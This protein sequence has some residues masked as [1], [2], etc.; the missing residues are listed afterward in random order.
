MT[1][2]MI[3]P[4]AFV[5]RP[6]AVLFDLD[7]TLYDFATAQPKAMEAARAKMALSLNVAGP[8]FDAA[9][10]QARLD[11]KARLG[12]TASS[13]SRLLYFQRTIEILGFRTQ[14][15]LALDLEQT[16]WRSMLSSAQLFEGAEDLL[17]ELRA[18]GIRL[19]VVTDLTAQIQFRKLIHFGIERYFDVVVTSEE[20]GVEKSGLVP[21][22]MAL[23]KLELESDARV[24]MIGDSSSDIVQ[25]RQALNCCAIQRCDALSRA[26]IYA[27]SDA[28][29]DSYPDLRAA[30]AKDLS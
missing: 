23:E 6:K 16:F 13:H 30:I 25:G 7:D 11:V 3:N 14:V 17:I 29:F 19:A 2:R 27:E 22:C 10:A 28:A 12:N 4:Q 24:W 9:F 8:S 26:R 18:A 15:L 1:L 20:A 21:F 5:E